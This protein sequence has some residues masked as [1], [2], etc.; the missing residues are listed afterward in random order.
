MKKGSRELTFDTI[1]LN[2]NS[3]NFH[4]EQTMSH[5]SHS[6]QNPQLDRVLAD[7]DER[8]VW[9]PLALWVSENLGACRR[10][11]ALVDEGVPDHVFESGDAHG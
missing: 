7:R 5:S 8:V 4:L 11:D 9:K 1:P 6:L 10:D 2:S 3:V